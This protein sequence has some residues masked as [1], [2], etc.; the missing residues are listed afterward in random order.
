MVGNEDE[1]VQDE[2]HHAVEGPVV[3]EAPVTTANEYYCKTITVFDSIKLWQ[4]GCACNPRQAKAA[5]K[6]IELE[7]WASTVPVV[8]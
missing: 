6:N 2:A 8:S 1:G 7:R 3:R 4:P 5:A